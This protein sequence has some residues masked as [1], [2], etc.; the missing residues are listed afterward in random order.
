[1]KLGPFAI[2]RV[3]WINGTAADTADSGPIK[4]NLEF[5]FSFVGCSFFGYEHE[6]FKPEIQFI[7]QFQF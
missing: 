2:Y 7:F 4:V 6:H 1:M 5:S 3:C